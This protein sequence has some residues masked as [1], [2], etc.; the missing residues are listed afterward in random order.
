[1]GI[2]MPNS[3]RTAAFS[4]VAFTVLYLAATFIPTLPEGAYSDAKVLELLQDSGTRSLI[5]VGS[6]L[7]IVAALSLLPFVSQ[8]TATLRHAEQG[9]TDADS[10]LLGVMSGGGLLYIAILLIAGNAFGSY[11][12]GIAVGEL[13]TPEDATL[14]RV[15]SDQGFGL[16]LVPGLLSAAVMILAASMLARRSHALPSWVC[17]TGFVFAPLLLL[18]AAWVPQFLVP[19]WTLMA[20]FTLQPSGVAESALPGARV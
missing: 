4:A 9:R 12:T 3:T 17:I 19:L 5:V 6:V 13:P 15:L 2:A 16:I 1:M 8:L 11:A 14:V 18:G 20:G 7:Y 10:P